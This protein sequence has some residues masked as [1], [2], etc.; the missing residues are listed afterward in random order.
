MRPRAFQFRLDRL[1]GLPAI[2]VVALVIGAVALVL[3]VGAIVAVAGLVASVGA[4]LYFSARRFLGKGLSTP[5]PR[6]EYRSAPASY[7][8]SEVREITVEVLPEN[9]G[10]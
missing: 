4:A 6:V 10:R 8:P 7:P 5:E 9:R 3:F 2:L 1:R